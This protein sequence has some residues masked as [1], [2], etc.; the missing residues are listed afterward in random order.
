M[1]LELNGWDLGLTFSAC[2]FLPEHDKCCRLHGHNYGVHLCVDGDV[3]QDGIVFDFIVLKRAMRKVVS[4]LDHHVL[5]P[6][7]SQ[8]MTLEI[9]EDHVVTSHGEKSYSFPLDDVV[10]L[11]LKVVSTEMLA[12]YILERILTMLELPPNVHK[13]EVGV[14][15]GKG[16]GAR[17]C[18]VL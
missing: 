1:K 6:G 10:I 17:V 18:K 9:K 2:H 7:N 3:G 4:E 15:E 8:V 11:D 14:D 16:Q 5:L 13:I 12:S